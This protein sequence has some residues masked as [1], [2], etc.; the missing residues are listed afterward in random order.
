M[1][2]KHRE[3]AVRSRLQSIHLLRLHALDKSVFSET[4]V[5]FDSRACYSMA[6]LW[7]YHP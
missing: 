3:Q 5:G 7:L 6:V 4:K 2:E 1:F